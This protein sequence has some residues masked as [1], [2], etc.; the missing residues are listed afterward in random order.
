MQRSKE[1][2][3]AG[4]EVL[5]VSSS[6][7]IIALAKVC[8]LYLLEKLFGEILVPEAVWKEITVEGKPGYEKVVRAKFIS[9]EKVGD[10]RLVALLEEF[11]DTGEAEAIA[12]ALERDADLLLVDDRDA[13]N[14]AK[15]LGL[16]VM[17]T[18]G[19]IALAKYKGLIP[20]TKPIIDKLMESGFWISRN[21]LEE[22]LKELDEL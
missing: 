16:Q 20:E 19:V 1:S 2:D 10:A 21:I 4:K 13:R 9:L 14:L 7:V 22:F 5:V 12:L 11:I 15:R 17:G 8:H 3:E 6:S 18:L